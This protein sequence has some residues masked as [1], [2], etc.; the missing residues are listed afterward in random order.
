MK[1]TKELYEELK[2]EFEWIR[3]CEM[4]DGGDI[5]R[6][7]NSMQK[8]M[9]QSFNCNSCKGGLAENKWKFVGYCS[10]IIQQVESGAITFQDEP[11]S[12]EI[13]KDFEVVKE[14]PKKKDAVS[15][16]TK[17]IEKAKKQTNKYV[18]GK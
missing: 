11:M 18:K 8:F 4:F 6:L 7:K 12:K 1:L 3:K 10:N 9:G 14:E 5:A 13:V 2:I 17:I 15:E 16:D